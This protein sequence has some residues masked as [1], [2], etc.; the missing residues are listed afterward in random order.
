MFAAGKGKGWGR[1]MKGGREG[2][3]GGREDEREER[4]G[5]G[6]AGW[7]G[8]AVLLTPLP[9]PPLAS[10]PLP[11]PRQVTSLHYTFYTLRNTLRGLHVA[12][13][14]LFVAGWLD[15]LYI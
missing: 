14:L 12:R 7:A 9:S 4:G 8:W 11:S 1:E 5:T 6:W 10:P 2:R 3:E 13:Y 15:T